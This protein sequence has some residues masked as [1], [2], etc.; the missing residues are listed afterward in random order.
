MAGRGLPPE[1]KPRIQAVC[2][3][4]A[5]IVRTAAGM[6]RGLCEINAMLSEVRD[7]NGRDWSETYNMAKTA[8]AV[9]SAAA[10]RRES[11]GTHYIL[12]DGAEDV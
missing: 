4:Y 5:G 2:D 1:L 7:I 9:L 3:K 8:H 10:R 12:E 6:E 11:A